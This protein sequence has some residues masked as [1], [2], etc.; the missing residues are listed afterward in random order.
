MKYGVAAMVPARVL[1]VDDT[2][3]SRYVVSRMLQQAGFEIAGEAATGRDAI[4]LAAELHP[5]VVILDVRLPDMSGF[6][7]AAQLRR[8]PAS[9]Q[10]AILQISAELTTSDLRARGLEEG[11][12]AYLTHPVAAHELIALVNALVR[13]R[14]ASQHG[15]AYA[16]AIARAEAA[17]QALAETTAALRAAEEARRALAES[18]ARERFLSEAVPAHVW[19]ATPDGQLDYV[20]RLAESYFGASSNDI[21]GTGWGEFVHPD[22][23]AEA[24]KRWERAIATGE[25]YE[26]EFRLRRADGSYRWHVARAQAMV[27]ADGRPVRWF[28]TVTDLHDER[29]TSAALER[30]RHFLATVLDSIS[31]AIAVCDAEGNLTR[32]NRAASAFFDTAQAPLS[33]AEWATALQ[34]YAEDG[35]TPMPLEER[36]FARALRRPDE[37]HEVPFVLL[38]AGG[39]PRALVGLARALRGPGGEVLGAVVAARDVTEQRR[40]EEERIARQA[41]EARERHFHTLAETIPQI[42]W[43]AEPDGQLDYFSSQW[44]VY[45]GLTLEE[46]Q[47]EKW[48]RMLHPDDVSHTVKRWLHSV[49]TGE[50]H[51]VECRFR[52]G[53]DETYRWHLTRAMPVRDAEGRIVKWFGTCTDLDDQKSV[54]EAHNAALEAV[55]KA[56]RRIAATLESIT[57]SFF[58]V[59]ADWRYTYMNIQAERYFGVP[60]ERMIGQVKW[61]IF[62]LLLGSMIESEYRRAMSDRVAVRFETHSPLTGRWV[63]ARVF[64]LE[65]EEADVVT[66]TLGRRGGLAV[67]FNDVTARRGAEVAL[68]TSEQRLREAVEVTGLGTWDWDFE[69]NVLVWSPECKAFFGLAPD[70]EVIPSRFESYLHPDDRPVRAAALEAATDPA[71]SGA[72][73]CEYRA[74]WSDGTTRWLRARGQLFFAEVRGERRAVRSVGTTLDVTVEKEAAEVLQRSHADLERLVAERTAQLHDA[75][76]AAEAANRAKSDFLA[77]MSHELRTP[78]NSVIGFANVLRRNAREALGEGELLYAER[79]SANGRH[80]LGLINDVLDLTKVESG[81]VTLE[82]T[83]VNVDTLVRDVVANFA[84]RATDSGIALELDVAG[85]AEGQRAL[86]PLRADERRLRQVLIN[87]LGNALK[88]TEAGGTVRVTLAS[89][90]ESGYPIRL[91]V[92]DTGIGVAPEAHARIFEAFEQADSDTSHRF[93]GTGLGLPISRALCDAMGYQLSLES[94]PGVGSTFSIIFERRVPRAPSYLPR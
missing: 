53:S 94:T 51:E 40:V 92:S 43:T 8:D 58:T 80:L 39:A 93:G 6:D 31:D 64:P 19:T 85:P 44:F 21:V 56:D 78:L 73:A 47:G 67:Y 24:V 18:E 72:Y 4:R 3:A 27:G 77:R 23:L 28:G 79:I 49:R 2:D 16:A 22:D 55:G 66:G 68:R 87:L 81:H 63:E 14:R 62:P 12:D 37:E 54:L 34:L 50:P 46:T 91:D 41:A 32:A 33:A 7:V 1:I 9:A 5:D 76:E 89:D 86:V 82:R 60:R 10:L 17:E 71:G 59:D 13:A 65:D 88:F 75:K 90:A 29:E 42:V 57:D 25:P 26:V 61:E 83:L 70:E 30:E 45:T 11:A 36:P 20:N 69:T 48:T 35:A 74:V 38:G 84:E 15:A 52:R